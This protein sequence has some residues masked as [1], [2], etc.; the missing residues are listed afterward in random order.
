MRDWIRCYYNS[1]VHSSR[2]RGLYVPG[3]TARKKRAVE[4]K[5]VMVA[6]PEREPEVRA[7]KTNQQ[8]QT[9]LSPKDDEQLPS[10][11]VM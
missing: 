2:D 11:A 8:E 9:I 7:K 3:Y 10:L 1:Y 5:A 4:A 6:V